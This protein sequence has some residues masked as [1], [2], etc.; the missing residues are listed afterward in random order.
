M[1]TFEHKGNFSKT[2]KFFNMLLH[3]DWKNVL[4]RYG[5]MGVDA[6]R[7]ATPVDT[8]LAASSW[9]Y[10]ISKDE[11]GYHLTWVNTDIEDGISVV[12]LI[13]RGH[14]TKSGTWFEGYHFIDEAIDPIIKRLSEEVTFE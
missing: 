10:V 2:E 12:V 4:D 3:K 5:R 7:A 8:G 1:I 13:D 9:D 6:L 11:K 14:A